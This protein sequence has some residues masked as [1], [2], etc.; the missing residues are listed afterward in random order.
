MTVHMFGTRNTSDFMF[1]QIGG[2]FISKEGYI[3]GEELKSK[4]EIQL[5]FVTYIPN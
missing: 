5:C 2:Y 1:F 3:V 4:P